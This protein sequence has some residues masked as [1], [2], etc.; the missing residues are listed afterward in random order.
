MGLSVKQ[1]PRPTRGPTGPQPSRL[2][3]FTHTRLARLDRAAALGAGEQSMEG[4]QV[5]VQEL[6][7]NLA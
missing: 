3:L 7:S 5:W 6:C 2:V 1:L 4:E